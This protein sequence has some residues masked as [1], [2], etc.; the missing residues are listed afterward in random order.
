MPEPIDLSTRDHQQCPY[1]NQRVL[2]AEYDAH[3]A[4]C[5][6]GWLSFM[7]VMDRIDGGGQR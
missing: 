3:V 1:C 2:F 5:N 7:S 4:R 6:E